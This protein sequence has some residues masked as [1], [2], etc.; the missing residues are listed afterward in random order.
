MTSPWLAESQSPSPA[1]QEPQ[2]FM[3]GL[4]R[5]PRYCESNDGYIEVI[6]DA[7][8]NEEHAKVIAGLN[9]QKKRAAKGKSK[10]KAR[11]SNE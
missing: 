5:V 11:K 9:E 10:K 3:T 6:N 7:S 4:S 8:D 2:V 1:L